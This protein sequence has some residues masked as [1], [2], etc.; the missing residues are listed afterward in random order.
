MQVVQV[1]VLL[2]LYFTLVQISAGNFSLA[3][4]LCPGG[5]E[6]MSVAQTLSNESIAKEMYCGCVDASEIIV[7]E[8]DQDGVIIKVYVV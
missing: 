2:N 4:E 6:L 3:V 8:N 7:C 5:Y 1:I